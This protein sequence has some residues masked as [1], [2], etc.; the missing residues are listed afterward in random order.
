MML[1]IS[2]DH[3]TPFVEHQHSAPPN[4]GSIS[5]R[6]SAVTNDHFQCGGPRPGPLRIC[7]ERL[8]V[9]HLWSKSKTARCTTRRH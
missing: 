5:G 7:A 8:A 4:S 3:E 9:M 2:R 6:A 1:A